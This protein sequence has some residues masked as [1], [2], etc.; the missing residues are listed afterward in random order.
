MIFNTLQKIHWPSVE[1]TDVTLIFIYILSLVHPYRIHNDLAKSPYTIRDPATVLM[2]G[3]SIFDRKHSFQLFL[4]H[5]LPRIGFRV[6]PIEVD[7]GQGLFC[8]VGC[9]SSFPANLLGAQ[10][11]YS[12][13]EPWVLPSM[14][15]PIFISW[16]GCG[17]RP[18]KLNFNSDLH[19]ALTQNVSR[20]KPQRII[21]GTPSF[22]TAQFR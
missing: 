20:E 16:R 19:A 18:Q 13:R 10:R 7:D 14:E 2:L 4:R 3:N 6:G 9:H 12:S 21:P 1:L 15:A 17:R 5:D 22:R 11:S 8:L